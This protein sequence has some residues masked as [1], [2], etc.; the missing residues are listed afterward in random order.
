MSL[1]DAISLRVVASSAPLGNAH[2]RGTGLAGIEQHV[3]QHLLQLTAVAL[4]TPG[5]VQGRVSTRRSRV[6][7]AR[8]KAF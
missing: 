7:A 3:D 2:R 1:S 5:G 6:W 8:C 4:G